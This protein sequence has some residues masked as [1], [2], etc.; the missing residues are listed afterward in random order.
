MKYSRL[1][2]QDQ[3][4]SKS[5]SS[6]P[7][8]HSL[9]QGG[10]LREIGP[11]LYGIMPI[12]RRVMNNITEIIRKELTAI[13]GEEFFL[14]LLSPGELWRE[15]GRD[16]VIAHDLTYVQDKQDKSLVL[17]PSHEESFIAMARQSFTRSDQLPAFLYQFQLRFRDEA[18]HGQGLVRAREFLMAD[19]F[20]LHTSEVGLNN[21]FPQ[22]FA[23]FQ[24]MFTQ[25]GLKVFIAPG[26]AEYSSGDPAYEILVPAKKGEHNLV[27]CQN[28]GHIANQD[29]AVGLFKTKASRLR[30][31]EPLADHHGKNPA[32][33]IS[34]MGVPTSRL[35]QC[36]IYLTVNSIVMTVLRGDQ[37]LSRDKLSRLIQ[38][39]VIREARPEEVEEMGL[40]PHYVSPLN[41]SMEL[42]DALNLKILVDNAVADSTNLS[43]PGNRE[44]LYYANSNFGRDYSAD[45][46]G[47]LARVN[48]ECRCYHCGGEVEIQRVVKLAHLYR[49]GD[50][51]ARSMDFTITDQRG[52]TAY[53]HL[54][55]YGLGIGRLMA[56]V[57][58]YRSDHQ[59][60]C[61]PMSITPFKAHLVVV[62]RGHRLLQIAEHVYSRIKD[63][64]LWDDRPIPVLQKFRD[65][66]RLGIP[67]RLVISASSLEDGS[68]MFSHRILSPPCRVPFNRIKERFA[69]LETLEQ[70]YGPQ[71]KPGIGELKQ[72]ISEYMK[73][74][75]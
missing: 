74:R 46:V 45:I 14:P 28:T 32:G 38:E 65:A 73:Q 20:S 40:V 6:N 43:I 34:A 12:G 59:S 29:V 24:R 42:K 39:P 56:T 25:F 30:N 61:W 35:V 36:H 64:V 44:G 72:Q 23:A 70:E 49:M 50:S 71:E 4:Q 41:L 62:G 16:Q 63:D 10:Y 19:A 48:S 27:I 17:S 55:S 51:F 33:V 52:E 67:I 22:V 15:T 75:Q 2:L 57:A 18:P 53:P 54:G 47:D 5:E 26:A 37:T 21:F 68:L 8:M 66:D 11:G 1:Y 7:G 31:L 9:L 60:L 69:E 13:G 58:E 3:E